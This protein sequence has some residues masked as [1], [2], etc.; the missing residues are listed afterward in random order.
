MWFVKENPDKAN[1]NT[2]LQVLDRILT[3]EVLP[4]VGNHTFIDCFDDSYNRSKASITYATHH[5]DGHDLF[6]A[7]MMRFAEA[8]QSIVQYKKTYKV[9]LKHG[10]P[11]HLGNT[12]GFFFAAVQYGIAS[13]SSVTFSHVEDY[14]GYKPV[15]YY[16]NQVAG[17]MNE[18]HPGV[19][20]HSIRDRVIKIANSGERK[21]L[22]A[23]IAGCF[24]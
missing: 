22:L 10:L 17:T 1:R 24:H 12:L 9:K 6:I 21:E 20:F 3:Y 19:N 13:R 8:E 18:L 4:K 7:T 16:C 23:N 14:F 15:I 5:S 11:A 2:A